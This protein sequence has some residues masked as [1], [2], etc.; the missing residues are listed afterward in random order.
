MFLLGINK[1]LETVENKIAELH[2]LLNIRDYGPNYI[3]NINWH[4]GNNGNRLN[5]FNL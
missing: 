2:I 5:T 1:N 3:Y 4:R